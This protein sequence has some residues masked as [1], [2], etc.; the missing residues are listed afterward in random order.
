MQDEV[1]ASIASLLVAYVSRAEQERSRRKPPGN[2]RAY[3]CYLRGIDLARSW[4]SPGYL[5]CRQMMQRA[6]AVDPEFASAYSA[7]AATYVR[8]WYEPR[9]PLYL[10]PVAFELATAAVRKALELD[11]L[12]SEGHAMMGWTLFWRGEHDRA[13]AAYERALE[14]NPNLADWRFGQILAHAGRAE[15]GIEAL[16]RARR[17]DPFMASGWHAFV[18]HAY[19]T[20]RR[21]D[22]ALTLFR[23]SAWNERR[24]SGQ[25][26]SGW[27]RFADIWDCTKR[28]V[29]RLRRSGL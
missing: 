4:D 6:I 3:D 8:S 22:E 2:W 5:N 20:L 10:D 24:R 15:D 18:G 25:A 26:K 16:Q 27:R 12:L 19:F 17:L 21:Y 13:I 9:D 7:L 11:P 29:A 1:A 14:I 23:E 28:H